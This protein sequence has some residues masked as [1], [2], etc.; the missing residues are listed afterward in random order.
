MYR[1]YWGSS[2][3]VGM[4]HVFVLQ[5]RLFGDHGRKQERE[6]EMAKEKERKRSRT[7]V[8]GGGAAAVQQYKKQACTRMTSHTSR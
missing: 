8:V 6:R 4:P 7:N 3:V 1:E 5:L 2:G